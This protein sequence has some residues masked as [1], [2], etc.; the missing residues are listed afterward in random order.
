MVEVALVPM[1]KQ[2]PIPLSQNVNS[3]IVISKIV[4]SK[5]MINRSIII[6]SINN[7]NINCI[8]LISN[9]INKSINSLKDTISTM[10]L[11]KLS[12]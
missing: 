11:F 2:K 3:Q 12:I 1:K 4:I 5:I 7:R 6:K 8:I 10:S 9:S